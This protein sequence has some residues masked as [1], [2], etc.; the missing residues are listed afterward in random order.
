MA[1][2]SVN[3]KSQ[4]FAARVPHE[5]ANA[6]EELKEVGETTGQFVVT[7]LQRE[8]K[9]R[10]RRKKSEKPEEYITKER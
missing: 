7:A 4:T 10:E 3:A 2:K 6:V 1:T 8:V 9:H 5:I